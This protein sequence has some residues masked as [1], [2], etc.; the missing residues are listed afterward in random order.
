MNPFLETLIRDEKNMS[1]YERG[2]M[3][4]TRPDKAIPQLFNMSN[5]IL[6]SASTSQSSV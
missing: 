1:I 5:A 2:E 3:G 6:L 4:F